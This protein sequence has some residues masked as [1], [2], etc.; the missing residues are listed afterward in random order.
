MNDVPCCAATYEHVRG[1][2]RHLAAH[3]TDVPHE[4]P[5]R[6]EGVID[7]TQIQ[8]QSTFFNNTDGPKRNVMIVAALVYFK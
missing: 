5:Q 8:K 1:T 4:L 6:T 2:G 3:P 7:D